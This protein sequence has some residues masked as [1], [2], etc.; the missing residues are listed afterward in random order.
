MTTLLSLMLIVLPWI[1]GGL[2]P[3]RQDLTWAVVLAFAAG[4]LSIC[5]TVMSAF[6]MARFEAVMGTGADDSGASEGEH[7]AG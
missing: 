4:F 2:H 7:A 1:F 6:D 3:D 5:A